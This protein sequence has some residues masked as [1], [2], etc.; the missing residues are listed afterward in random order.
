MAQ[1]GNLAR[2]IAIVAAQAL[3]RIIDAPVLVALTFNVGDGV[4]IRRRRGLVDK[5]AGVSLTHDPV[6]RYVR[7]GVVGIA[8]AHVG[9]HAREPHLADALVFRLPNAVGARGCRL[10][11]ALV[12]QHGM[13]GRALIVQC[14]RV[15]GALNSV[16]QARSG[17]S[18]GKSHWLTPRVISSIGKPYAATV[19]HRP[20]NRILLTGL[21]FDLS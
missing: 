12:P 3:A 20:R 15:T 2:P 18:S 21:F 17:N 16:A 6:E 8:A 7:Q 11:V 10:L 1:V 19:S 4:R 13:E 5:A 14:Q 9:M